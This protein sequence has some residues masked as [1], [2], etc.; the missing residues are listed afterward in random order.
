MNKRNALFS[1]SCAAV[2]LVPSFASADVFVWTFGGSGDPVSASGTLDA[3]LINGTANYQVTDGDGTLY[4]NN[5]IATEKSGVEIDVTGQTYDLTLLPGANESGGL[6][7]TPQDADGTNLGYDNL[8]IGG[9]SLDSAG[10]VF[11]S[12]D[13]ETGNTLYF[14]PGPDNFVFEDLPDGTGWDV[15]SLA[16][17]FAAS[18]VSHGEQP[19]GAP[20]PSTI[21][22]AGLALTVLALGRNIRH[23]AD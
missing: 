9:A 6:Y 10:I 22:L 20:E 7:W 2:L 3:T 15:I 4:V 5:L 17:G 12:T 23:T 16:D 14:G 8:L 19:S 18:D 13:P 21:A 11:T 1:F